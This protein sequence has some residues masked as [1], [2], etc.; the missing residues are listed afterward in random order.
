MRS[1]RIMMVAAVAVSAIP[2]F[3]G[4]AHA[5]PG[6]AVP[7]GT[8]AAQCVVGCNMQKKVCIQTART[9][10]LACKQNCRET[11]AHGALGPCMKGCMAT[12]RSDSTG[13][14]MCHADQTTCIEGCVPPKPSTPPTA[15]ESCLGTCGTDLA[16]C[17]QG[18]VS[19]AKTCVSGCRNAPNRLMC[20]EG[21][22]TAAKSGAQTCATDFE[23][24]GAGC[25]AP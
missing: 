23:S 10:A 20:L 1:L 5:H 11:A 8:S 13:I 18:V 15:R 4:S 25:P 12:F 6:F 24:C 16:G 19:Q 3:A 7:A 22:A 21:C 9:A 14:G 2:V 17:A